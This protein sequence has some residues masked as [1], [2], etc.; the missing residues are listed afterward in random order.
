MILDNGI[1]YEEPLFRPPAEANSFI[2]QATIGCSWNKCSFCEMYSN[3]QFRAN[4]IDKIENDIK[5]YSKIYP[6]TKKVFIAD[7]NALVLPNS[8]LIKIL[9]LLI[10]YFPKLHRVSSYS[11]PSDI[12]RK[13]ES[14]LNE[15]LIRKLNLLYIGIESGSDKILQFI[16]KSETSASTINGIN[17]AHSAGFETSVMILTGLGGKLFSEEHIVESAKLINRINPK[18]LSTLVLSF[19]FGVDHYRSKINYDYQEMQIFDLLIELQLFISNLE[20]NGT[21]FRSDH[22]SNYL[23]LKGVLNKDKNKLLDILNYTITNHKVELL[24]PEWAR[25]L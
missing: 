14:E 5:L 20:L 21:I 19:P 8:Q 23:S 7:A 15:L 13:T 18:Y 3:K 24:R 9:D 6:D 25:G 4:C 12:L 17:Y 16:N 11:L 10:Q 22:A 1:K 2:L